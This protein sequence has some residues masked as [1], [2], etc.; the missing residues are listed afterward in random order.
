MG[1]SSIF[2]VFVMRVNATSNY[3]FKTVSLM[4]F[5]VFESM[6][7]DRERERKKE[8]HV[9]GTFAV[10]TF[11]CVCHTITFDSNRIEIPLFLSPPHTVRAIAER[12]REREERRTAHGLLDYGI[13]DAISLCQFPSW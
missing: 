5:G 2:L 4:D 8:Y 10:V 11:V 9:F 6:R 12:Q 1:L 7:R 13:K 3:Y